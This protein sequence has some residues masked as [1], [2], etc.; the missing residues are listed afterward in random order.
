MALS[1]RD[2]GS[3]QMFV[4]VVPQP[5]LDGQYTYLGKA[6][7]AWDTLAETDI[8]LSARVVPTP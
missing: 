2:T 5:H 1:G 4:T 6:E 7:G 3:S 8:I